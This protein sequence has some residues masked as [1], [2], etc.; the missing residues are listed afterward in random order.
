MNRYDGNNAA[1]FLNYGYEKLNDEQRQ[2]SK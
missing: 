2:D 1:K